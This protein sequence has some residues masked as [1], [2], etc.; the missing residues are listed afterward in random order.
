MMGMRG[1]NWVGFVMLVIL[2][3]AAEPIWLFLGLDT[4]EFDSTKILWTIPV[5]AYAIVAIV[6]LIRG[7]PDRDLS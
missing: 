7:G 4:P 2:I 6:L 1:S 5:A 3:F